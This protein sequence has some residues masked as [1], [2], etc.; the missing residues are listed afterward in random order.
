[1][2]I[3]ILMKKKSKCTK[4]LHVIFLILVPGSA[5][6]SM[7]MYIIL[8]RGRSRGRFE[9]EATPLPGALWGAGT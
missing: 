6:V 9:R 3:I 1:M 7:V 2:L 5:R 4:K 8:V